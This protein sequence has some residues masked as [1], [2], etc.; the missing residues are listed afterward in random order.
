MADL[1]IL[2]SSTSARTVLGSLTTTFTPSPSCFSLYQPLD[3]RGL[4]A[5]VPLPTVALQAVTCVSDEF[6]TSDMVDDVKCWPPSTVTHTDALYNGWGLYSP[7]LLCPNGYT[8]ACTALAGN[9]KATAASISGDDFQFQFPL[10]PSETAAGCCPRYVDSATLSRILASEL[11]RALLSP[12]GTIVS[13]SPLTT[14]R[15]Y[16]RVLR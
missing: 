11:R 13:S 4:F 14:S 6:L 15:R 9:K 10:L 5:T 3:A 8:T 2:G 1:P 12:V 16:S 7:G